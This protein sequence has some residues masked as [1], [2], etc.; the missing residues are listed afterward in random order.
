MEIGSN[1]K[2]IREKEK[3]LKKEDVAKAL[4]IS[5]KAYNNIENNNTDITLK[6]L[7]EIADIFDVAP[8][9]ILT[10]QDKSNVVKF[11][12]YTGII[13]NTKY[14]EIASL[15]Q[16]LKESANE[17]TALQSRISAESI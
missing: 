10:Y 3:G 11:N 2:A 16:Q 9:Y 14:S 8:D 7:Y 17:L 4:G 6:R 15:E 13:M 5:A 1:I 12:S